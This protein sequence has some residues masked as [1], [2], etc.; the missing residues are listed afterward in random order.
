MRF[1]GGGESQALVQPAGIWIVLLDREIK[2]DARC[3]GLGL[4]VL[5]D[6]SPDAVALGV[7][8]KRTSPAVAAR[9]R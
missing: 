3:R 6:G 5:D 2:G 4:E 1:A 7:R 8:K 9:M